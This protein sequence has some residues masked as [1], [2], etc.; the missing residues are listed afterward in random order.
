MGN[1]RNVDISTH[2]I[3]KNRGRMSIPA[4]R[5]MI[6]ARYTHSE[7]QTLNAISGKQK[8]G[9]IRDCSRNAEELNYLT[10]NKG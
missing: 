7:Y 10:T 5:R 1:G 8:E 9:A 6:E 4:L 3:F 2:P